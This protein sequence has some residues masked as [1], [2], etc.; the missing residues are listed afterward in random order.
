MKNW[1]KD[2]HIVYLYILYQ[3]KIEVSLFGWQAW[4]TNKCEI[5]PWQFSIVNMHKYYH[6]VCKPWRSATEN[7]LGISN[8]VVEGVVCAEPRKLGLDMI[9][10][11]SVVNK[12]QSIP[13]VA[14]LL[15][16]VDGWV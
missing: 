8:L 1:I 12:S 10:A 11:L 2:T 6:W 7:S 13:T 16:D 5:C 14:M 3:T 15:V 9:Y 4:N